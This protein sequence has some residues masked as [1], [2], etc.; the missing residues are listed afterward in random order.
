MF[1]SEVVSDHREIFEDFIA[2]LVGFDS[3]KVIVEKYPDAE[4]N[5]APAEELPAFEG[6]KVWCCDCGCGVKDPI[7]VPIPVCSI[8]SEAGLLK[9]DIEWAWVS[10]CI[11]HDGLRHG[12]ELWDNET[13]DVARPYVQLWGN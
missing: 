13:D 11:R 4:I 8:C 3:G 10:P 9:A 12:M 7:L 5:I 6:D 2:K 1:R